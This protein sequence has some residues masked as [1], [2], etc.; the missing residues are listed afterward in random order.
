MNESDQR[1]DLALLE[2]LVR[3]VLAE[4]A[5]TGVDTDAAWTAMAPRLAFTPAPIAAFP[6]MVGDAPVTRRR[7]AIPR[8]RRW[9][10]ALVAVA[11]ALVAGVVLTAAGY[12]G[13]AGPFSFG[14]FSNHEIRQIGES[15]LYTRIGQTQDSAGVALTL[16]SAYADSGTTYIAYHVLP[17]SGATSSY[18]NFIPDAYSLTD[19]YGEEPTT[20]STTECDPY[21]GGQPQYCLLNDGPFH[22]PAGVTQLTL[23]LSIPELLLGRSG[24]NGGTTMLH[25]SWQF[26]FTLPFHQRS[27]GATNPGAQPTKQP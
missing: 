21:Q 14:P 4:H 20:G 27:L 2:P 6:A 10:F 26:T 18:N 5:P 12:F 15:H 11:A 8:A 25:G 7:A 17:T 16:D 22:P 13:W 24:A 9:R 3:G 23:T 1:D 19:Q